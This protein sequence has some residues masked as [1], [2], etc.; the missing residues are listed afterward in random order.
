MH[1]SAHTPVC[2]NTT[3]FSAIM[4]LPVQPVNYTFEYT[5]N[6]CMLDILLKQPKSRI[7]ASE[8]EPVV[9][10]RTD[11]PVKSFL[12][13]VSWRIV[14]TIDTMIISYF[15]TGKVTMAVSIGSVEVI[16]KTILYYF[17]ER[18]WI[19]IHKIRLKV[20]TKNNGGQL[21]I[22]EPEG[23]VVKGFSI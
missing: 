8:K 21:E 1:L 12:K 14:G 23:P 22:E 19:H 16:T 6:C 9:V 2:I 7:A 5:E 4:L 13:S 17:H 15:V 10:V 18:A 20:F 11:K 3:L